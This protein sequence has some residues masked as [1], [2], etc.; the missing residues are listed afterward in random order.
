[1]LRRCRLVAPIVVAS[2]LLAGCHLFDNREPA[3][4]RWGGL[5]SDL[6][7]Q[8]DAEPGIDVLTGAAVPVRAYIESRWLAGSMG[9]LDHAYP[10]FTR[11]VP[12]DPPNAGWGL[13]PNVNHKLDT[14]LIG[15]AQYHILSL[16]RSADVVTATVCS[17]DY[18]VARQADDGKDADNFESVARRLE[19]RPKGIYAERVTLA[20]PGD[21]SSSMPPQAG[22][23]PAPSDDVFGNWRIT[24]YLF[25]TSQ[26]GFSSQWPTFDA[27]LAKCVEK[28]PD[29]PERR[30]F[31]TD[32]NHPRSDFPTSPPS[33]GWPAKA[34]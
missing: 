3:I 19:W 33:P 18:A 24:G 6:R 4:Q 30:A 16:T 34:A 22:P 27:E 5:L 25:S 26:P 17:Y 7:Y 10:G 11:A 15:N 12:P 21:E 2:T 29:P 1:V 13:R 8:W 9:N 20:A 32:G 31:L 28:A 14:A 23:S